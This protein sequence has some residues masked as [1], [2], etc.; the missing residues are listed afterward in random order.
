MVALKVCL[1]VPSAFHFIHKCFLKLHSKA[2]GTENCSFNQK[3]RNVKNIHKWSLEEWVYFWNTYKLNLD[4]LALVYFMTYCYFSAFNHLCISFPSYNKYLLAGCEQDGNSWHLPLP[5]DDPLQPLY[6][7]PPLPLC[8]LEAEGISPDDD[9]TYEKSDP[10]TMARACRNMAG[11][12]LAGNGPKGRN[13]IIQIL[14]KLLN[15][16][17]LRAV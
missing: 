15:F 4:C 7:G 16:M 6:R 14:L 2:G 1:S 9:G 11:W 3:Q 8:V 17:F 13:F 5:H 12:K 10:G